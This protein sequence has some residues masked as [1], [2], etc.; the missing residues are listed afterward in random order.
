MG[1]TTATD[2]NCQSTEQPQHSVTVSDFVLDTF[3]VTVGRFRNFVA[4][5][6]G[7]PP[8]AGA[9]AN[10]N[11]PGSGWVASWN[12]SL[13]TSQA[14]LTGNVASCTNP[15]GNTVTGTWTSSPGANENYAMTCVDWYEAFAFCVWDGGRLPTEA[16]WEYAAAGGSDDWLYPWGSTDP[17]V[18][19]ALANDQYSDD[20]VFVAVGSHP[21]GN[22]KWGH[23]DLAGG[24]WEWDLDVFNATWYANGGSTCDN[25]ANLTVGTSR[26]ARGGS[27]SEDAATLRAA[28]RGRAATPPTGRNMGVGIRCARN[29]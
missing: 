5:F 22:G 10:P 7:T 15:T 23:R 2:P 13:D 3:E 18:T 11:I 1:C 21:S 16:E 26:V 4:A 9:G 28:N 29:G 19:I 14:T 6:T 24:L 27:W 25:C 8:A 12:S 17:S 20:S